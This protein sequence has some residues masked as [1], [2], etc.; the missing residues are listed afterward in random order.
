MADDINLR[1]ENIWELPIKQQSLIFS[2]L[3]KNKHFYNIASALRGNDLQDSSLKWLFTAR[4]RGLLDMNDIHQVVRHK[5]G[6]KNPHGRFSREGL[7]SFL[8]GIAVVP[9]S[10]STEALKHYFLH[11]ESALSSLK[12]LDLIDKNEFLSLYTLVNQMEIFISSSVDRQDR[13]KYIES[14]LIAME[15]E[16][17]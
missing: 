10:Q 9:S 11:V 8:E 17:E 5:K 6:L 2:E 12:E 1:P 7:M 13:K 4:I 16:E 15:N 14:H 3:L